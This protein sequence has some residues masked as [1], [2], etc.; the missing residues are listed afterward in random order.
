MSL[1]SDKPWVAK[2][3]G[4]IHLLPIQELLLLRCKFLADG[5]MTREKVE[6]RRRRPVGSILI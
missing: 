6:V 3:L 4:Q 5:A 1:A 2:T